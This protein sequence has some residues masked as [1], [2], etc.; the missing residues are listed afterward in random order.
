MS[1]TSAPPR[2]ASAGDAT[3]LAATLAENLSLA[4]VGKRDAVRRAL[5]AVLS[6]G[7]L[8]IEDVPGVGKTLLA[9]ALA[10]SLGGSFRRVQ[11]T[12]DLLPSDLTGVAIYDRGRS[13]WRFNPGPLFANVVLVD[14][15]NRA[16]PRTQS[17]LLEAMEERQVSVDG[18]TYR[19][20]DP[21][22]VV[23]T[24]NPH[25][26]LGTFAL[27]E[28]QRDRFAMVVQM[29]LPGR[30]AERALLLGQGGTGALSSLRPVTNPDELAQAISAV[31]QVHC[32]PA[33]ADYVLNLADAT[34][35]EPAI[36]LGTSPRAALS[37]LRSAQAHA[38]IEGRTYVLPDDVKAIAA[39]ALAHRMIMA[40]GE[41]LSA[42]TGHIE[43]LLRGVPVPTG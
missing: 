12:P 32:T 11:G 43:R 17:A 35:Q 7:H 26:Q 16:T 39:S 34:R 5:V 41:N 18:T 36:T 30:Q 25:E 13:E 42:A 38:V 22:I 20:P 9:K 33:I 21:F 40:E 6:G 24:Q 3:A 29:G 28:G 8:L 2:D 10:R 27:V 23:A 19:L 15:I 31:R 4:L 37:L 14:E 1:T